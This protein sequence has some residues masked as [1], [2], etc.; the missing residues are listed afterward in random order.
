MNRLLMAALFLLPVVSA[1]AQDYGP[2]QQVKDLGWMVG[3]WSGSG[4]IA[5][6]G[7]EVEITSTMTVSFDGQFLK[8]VSADKSAGSILTKTTMT[9]W[10]PKKSEYI[11][12]TFT[13]A[14]PTARIA[15]GKLNEGKLE[16]VSD[17]WEAEGFTMVARETLSKL[18][19]TKFGMKMEYQ[20]GDKWI[21]GMDIVLTKQ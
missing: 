3:T 10:E 13:N 19:D 20:S 17:P 15:H 1:L 12:Y 9:G 14:A 8:A 11:S 4:K 18:S 21:T 16:M 7:H 2:P 5:F 6:G